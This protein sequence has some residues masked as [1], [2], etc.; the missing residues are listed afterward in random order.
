MFIGTP[1]EEVHSSE[2]GHSSDVKEERKEAD[3]KHRTGFQVIVS[4]KKTKIQID[5]ISWPLHRTAIHF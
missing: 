5:K 4:T 2:L 3:Y 1:P